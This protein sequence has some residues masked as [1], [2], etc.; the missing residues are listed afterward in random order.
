[1]LMTSGIEGD[2]PAV[3]SVDG[4]RRTPHTLAATEA[5]ANAR[6]GGVECWCIAGAGHITRGIPTTAVVVGIVIVIVDQ[7]K[8]PMELN[9]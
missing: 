8:R 3:V 4:V 7:S 5:D 2:Q 6:A 1:M 9:V